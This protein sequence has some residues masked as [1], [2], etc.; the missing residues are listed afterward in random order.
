M[1]RIGQ[2]SRYFFFFFTRFN[3]ILA[4]CLLYDEIKG[5]HKYSLNT[6][7]FERPNRL[8]QSD[9]AATNAFSY[10]PSNYV[11][12]KRL[13]K[14]LNEFD[15]NK[16]FLDIGCGKGRVLSVAAH[17]GFK[18]IVGV[19]LVENYCKS[20]QKEVYK[21]SSQFPSTSF[22]IVCNDAASFV[23]PKNIQCI[24]F[25]NPFKEVMIDVMITNITNSFK[26]SPR[27]IYVIYLNP[28][29][30]QNFLSAGFKEIFNTS[31]FSYIKA[32]ILCLKT[33]N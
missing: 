6:T 31:R 15:H 10:M 22:E 23:I 17:F 3:P 1:L 33:N 5:E 2:Y 12:L 24:F 21:L 30:K 8:K 18:Q 13:F 25:Y 11:L 20:A 27:N 19:E 14:K 32:T 9:F 7:D 4:T 29:F 28:L 16:T 26:N